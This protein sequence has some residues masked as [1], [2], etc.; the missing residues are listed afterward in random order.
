LLDHPLKTLARAVAL[1][2]TDDAGNGDTIQLEDGTYTGHITAPDGVTIAGRSV[3]GTV[4]EA[5]GVG[6]PAFAFAG[7]AH[8]ENLTVEGA[9]AELNITNAGKIVIDT[10]SAPGGTSRL[11][12]AARAGDEGGKRKEYEGSMRTLRSRRGRHDSRYGRS[13][14]HRSEDRPEA[15]VTPRGV[16]PALDSSGWFPPWH[17]SGTFLVDAA[18]ALPDSFFTASGYSIMSAERRERSA[19]CQSAQRGARLLTANP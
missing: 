12:V 10:C 19:A 18:I 1:A 2:G 14:S 11:S 9:D 15:C 6:S 7:S 4:I 13:S 8:I 3:T 17:H 5:S 16:G